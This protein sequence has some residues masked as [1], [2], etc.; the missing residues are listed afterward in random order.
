MMVEIKRGALYGLF[1]F[2]LSVLLTFLV[3]AQV[4]EEELVL[5]FVEGSDIDTLD[6][7]ITRSR[8]TEIVLE[9]VFNKLVKWRDT[10][11]SAIVGDL[12]KSWEV[13]EDGLTWRFYLREG[14]YFHD[15]TIFNAESVKVTIERML[16]PATA[17]PNRA[18]FA[19]IS[20]VII[21]NDFTVELRTRVPTATLLENLAQSEAAML[22]PTAVRKYGKDLGRHP[23]GTGP[24]IVEEWIPGERCVLVRNPNY[25]GDPPK[26]YKIVYRPVP[27]GS[28]RVIEL[29][30]GRAH[31]VNRIPPEEVERLRANPDIE[32]LILPSTFSVFFEL[33]NRLGKSPFADVRVRQ[34]VNY[35][36]DKEA[37]VDVILKDLGRVSD[38][39][40][41]PGVQFRKPLQPYPYDPDKAKKL[42]AEAGYP[43][44][45]K[46]TMW[47]CV[48]RYLKDFEVAQAVQAYL[49]DVGIMAELVPFEWAAYQ[50]TLYSPAVE[51]AD[52]WLLGTSFPT[53]D[54][55]VT[56]KYECGNPSNLT[57][58]CDQEMEKLLTA[59]RTILDPGEREKIYHRIQ[60]K[61]WE[62]AVWLYLYDQVQI[63]GIRK[64]I[65]GLDAYSFEVLLFNNVSYKP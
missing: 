50:A 26:P 55:R 4:G 18:L 3:L 61:V 16:D 57:G 35:A 59:G 45:F 64:G 27:D 8:P 28:A 33:N 47:T 2:L 7:Q 32:I 63:I 38:S 11:L 60:E 22:S 17:S 21:C 56:R 5:V 44:G 20:E 37:I 23:V 34:A 58:Y 41:P 36:V 53:A 10:M 51:N 29:E 13:S 49:A 1:S 15:G 6:P 24:Y 65:Q 30:A 46:V 48:G 9:H 12:A 54:W 31:I 52:M 19:N 43:N 39:I 25:F 40:F 62:E 42:L 14:V